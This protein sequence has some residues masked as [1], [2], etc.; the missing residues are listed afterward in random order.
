MPQPE[1]LNELQNDKNWELLLL[2][3]R[4]YHFRDC[5]KN[6]KKKEKKKRKRNIYKSSTEGAD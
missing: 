5:N 1:M 3:A 4:K 2:Q 6:D